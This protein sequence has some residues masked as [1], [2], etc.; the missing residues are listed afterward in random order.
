[1]NAKQFSVALGEVD[2]KFVTEALIYRRNNQSSEHKKS[3]V[4]KRF[5]TA[6]NRIAVVAAVVV[7]LFSSAVSVGAVR[8]PFIEMIKTFFGNHVELSFEGDKKYKIEEIYGIPEIPVGFELTQ[9]ITNV[10]AVFRDYENP[11]GHIISFSQM[12]T[13][14]DTTVDVDNEHA[15]GQTILVNDLEVYVVSSDRDDDV[16]AA[17]WA[18]GGYSFNLTYIGEIEIDSLI[19]LIESIKVVGTYT[20]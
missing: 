19:E 5:N 17:F 13:G 1:M 11:E 18:E 15:T 16:V 3:S 6:S 14:N 8:E 20:E 4:F 10:A 9:E 7:V 2:D 12:T